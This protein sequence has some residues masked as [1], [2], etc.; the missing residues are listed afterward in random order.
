MNYDFKHR[1]NKDDSLKQTG[2]QK[3][4]EWTETDHSGIG[5]ADQQPYRIML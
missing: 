4:E 1:N 3:H 5:P 2:K